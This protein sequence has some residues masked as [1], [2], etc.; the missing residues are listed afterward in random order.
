MYAQ[1]IHNLSQQARHRFVP[2]NCGGIPQDLIENELFGHNNGAY[3]GANR[4]QFGLIHEA[5][6]GTIF[7]DEVDSL[8]LVSQVKLLRFLQEREYRLLGSVKTLKANVRVIA[9]SNVN[10][11][12]A[13]KVGTFRQ[14]LYYR[15]NVLAV[16]L[17]PLRERRED[18]PLLIRYFLT[19]YSDAFNKASV[20]IIPSA[21]EKL[22][23]YDWPGNIRELEHVIERAIALSSDPLITEKELLLGNAEHVQGQTSFRDAKAR[24]IKEFESNY[25]Q[26]LLI[27]YQGNIT[28][29]AA[30]ARKNRRAFWELLRKH[31]VEI[32][33][34]RS[35]RSDVVQQ[36]DRSTSRGAASRVVGPRCGTA[37]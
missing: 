6:G 16:R 15:L 31:D 20:A 25:V 4:C 10:L 36:A 34:F 37:R 29:A 22:V 7:L 33:R 26:G 28:R 24:V 12:D 9:A 27:A 35:H 14:D 1:A 18:I 3:T 8:P 2:V 11:E 19:K 23:C 17:P 30:A 32:D 5:E 13:V 21:L